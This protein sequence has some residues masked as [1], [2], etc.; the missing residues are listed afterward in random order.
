MGIY[1]E[2]KTIQT[3]FPEIPFQT[4]LQWATINGAKAL[5]IEN[6]YGSFEKRKASEVILLNASETR[7]LKENLIYLHPCLNFKS[8]KGQLGF[9]IL[10]KNKLL[11]LLSSGYSAL[12]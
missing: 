12:F 1:E 3:N 8:Q 11:R 5:G 2:V 10:L 6:K 4:I 9:K 7:R